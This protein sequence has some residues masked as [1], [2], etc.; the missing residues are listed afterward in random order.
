MDEAGPL[1]ELVLDEQRRGRS[2]LFQWMELY[3]QDILAGKLSVEEA[4]RRFL[5]IPPNQRRVYG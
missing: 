5:Q 2:N 4:T 1:A 3:Y